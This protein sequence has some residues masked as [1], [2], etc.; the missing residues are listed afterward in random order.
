MKDFADLRQLLLAY[1]L[2]ELSPED[3]EQLDE[4]IICDQVFSDQIA[5]A[6]YDLLDDYR[7]GRLARAQ[8]RRVEK[9]FSRTE[10]WSG[11]DREFGVP[12]EPLP[13]RPRWFPLGIVSLACLS[14]GLLLLFIYLHRVPAPASATHSAEKPGPQSPSKTPVAPSGSG[15][16]T[17]KQSSNESLAVLLLQP[18]VAR[19]GASSVLELAPSTQ[20]VRVQWVVPEGVTAPAFTLSVAREGVILKTIGQR[21]NL[22][23]IGRD[24]VAEF[25]LAPGVIAMS[26]KEAR[27]LFVVSTDDAQHT[28]EGDYPVIVRARQ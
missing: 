15:A 23:K 8:L 20:V 5:E 22:Q 10:L 3:R 6:G 7:A 13:V 28:A 16:S 4:R 25:D 19:D 26:P 24:L 17:A 9:A 27:F 14:M 18:A 11:S 2:G 21:R 1:K 12:K